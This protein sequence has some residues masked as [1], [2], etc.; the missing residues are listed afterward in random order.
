MIEAYY[1][2][3]KAPFAKD[4]G[5]GDTYPGDSI[6]EFSQRLE[7]MK[8]KRGILLA[9]GE[10][11][12]GKTLAVRSFVERLNSNQYKSFYI[13][14]ST[15]SIIDFYRQLSIT[16]GGEA[17]YRKSDL[18]LS[19]QNTIRDYV[20]N[21]KRI[22]VIIFDECHLLSNEN[23][24]ELQIITN[25][26][27]DSVDPAIF[28]LIGQP[29]IRERLMSPIHRSINQRISLKYH[30]TP[31]S[32]KETSSYIQHHLKLC[33]VNTPLFN[34][35]ALGA[36]YQNSSGIP[37]VINSIAIKAMT[38]GSLERKDVL[39]EEEVYMASKEL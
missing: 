31:L 26:Q 39:T 16:L 15:V 34:E 19:I 7:Y 1:N 30:I 25:F 13:P 38:I 27:M 8:E 9:T 21:T 35:N 17:R 28:I 24:Y 29:H 5:P 37:R 23:L 4:I 33:G 3:R 11:G 36:I 14:L 10:P 22:P 6:L 18:F 2:L 32:K 20:E 12:V